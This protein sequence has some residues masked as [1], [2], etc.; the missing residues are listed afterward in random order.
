MTIN[1]IINILMLASYNVTSEF[2]DFQKGSLI[3]L[4][5]HKESFH[6]EQI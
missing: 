1:I 2:T 4:F 5:V 6:Q 3:F